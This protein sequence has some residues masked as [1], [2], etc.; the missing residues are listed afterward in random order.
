MVLDPIILQLTRFLILYQLVTIT[1]NQKN[2]SALVLL[3]LAKPFDTVNHKI[4]LNKLENYGMRG[5][6]NQFLLLFLSH[7][8]QY[9]FFNNRSSSLEDIKIGVP[10]GS[11]FGPRLFLLYINDLPNSV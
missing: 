4:L 6:V 1:S 8:T 9:V 2:Y 3:D 5:V 11:F 10:Q 7:R